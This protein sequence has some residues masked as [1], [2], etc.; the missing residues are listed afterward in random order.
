MDCPHFLKQLD[1]VFP[2]SQDH[3]DPGVREAV[4]HLAECEACAREVE[5]RRQFDRQVAI[6]VRDVPVPAEA[7]DRLLR[8]LNEGH[9]ELVSAPAPAPATPAPNPRRLRRSLWKALAPV[10]A[11]LI[12]G[13][14]FVGRDSRAHMPLADVHGHVEVQFANVTLDQYE[15]LA[16]FSGDFDPA[17]D[18]GRWRFVTNATPRGVDFD[19]DGQQD[20]AVYWINRSVPGILLVLS[21]GLVADPPGDTSP[22]GIAPRYNPVR[23]AWLPAGSDKVHLCVL[24]GAASEPDLNRLLK[25]VLDSM[26]A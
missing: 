8:Q 21:P 13:W 9:V 7:R 3:D 25:Y 22:S 2:G 12:A 5:V 18:D 15:Q 16:P 14:W 10:A 20:A 11:L 1:A 23:V 24:H 26:T 4:A 19:A 6:L 17:I